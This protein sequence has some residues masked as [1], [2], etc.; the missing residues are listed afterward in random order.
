MRLR[1]FEDALEVF[2][3]QLALGRNKASAWANI[4]VCLG[5][6]C[7][8]DEAVEALNEA[9]LMRPNDEVILRAYDCVIY[10]LASCEDV[11]IKD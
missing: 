2:R 8:L 10:R 7:R 3:K 6:L 11:V 1:R 4:G 9:I 5:Y